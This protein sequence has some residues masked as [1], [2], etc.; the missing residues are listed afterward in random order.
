MLN[1][2][3]KLH[4][5][6]SIIVFSFLITLLSTWVYK[7]FTDQAKMKEIREKMKEIQDRSKQFKDNPDKMM[8]LQQEMMKLSGE[9][10]RASMKIT[11]ITLIPFLII[12][13]YLK[14]LYVGLG[15][16]IVWN[17]NIP[18]LGTGIGWFLSY[19][20]FSILSSVLLR[21][22]MKVY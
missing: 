12:F 14:S 8:E 3:V 15:D 16:L 4:P 6:I 7:R 20:L 9:Q 22:V 5:L 21:K 2:I 19:V 11:L 10:M 1:E 17:V 18:A 13:T